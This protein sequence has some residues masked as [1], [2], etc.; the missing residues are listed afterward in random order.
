M[1]LLSKLSPLRLAKGVK[2]MRKTVRAGLTNTG[3]FTKGVA[4]G[5]V[6]GVS[7]GVSKGVS[8]ITPSYRKKQLLSASLKKLRSGGTRRR[9]R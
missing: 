2:K 9:Y 6:T 1:D 5:M 7:K 3:D 8:L 4:K